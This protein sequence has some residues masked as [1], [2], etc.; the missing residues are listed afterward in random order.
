MVQWKAS[1]FGFIPEIGIRIQKEMEIKIAT[2]EYRKT[3]ID[4]RPDPG[5]LILPSGDW[6]IGRSADPLKEFIWFRIIFMVSKDMGFYAMEI[7][8]FESTKN[9]EI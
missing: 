7:E 9:S 8:I 5:R 6:E 2:M 1:I 4:G 3:G